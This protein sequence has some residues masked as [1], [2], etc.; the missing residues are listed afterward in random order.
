MRRTTSLPR[1]LPLCA[2]FAGFSFVGLR[3]FA[4]ATL[5]VA[6]VSALSP[7]SPASAQTARATMSTA[8]TGGAAGLTDLA[9]RYR[10][11]ENRL[12]SQGGLRAD[13]NAR[14]VGW[15]QTHLARNFVSIAMF[16]EY[17]RGL[18]G[19]PTRGVLR[20]WTQPVAISVSFGGSVPQAQRASDMNKIG[21][22]A[23]RLSQATGHPVGLT[24][25]NANV[26]VLV[27]SDAERK[28]LGPLLNRIAPDLGRSA[29]NA[30]ISAPPNILCMVVAQPH[31]DATRGYARAVVL[32][33]A[34]HPPRMRTSCIEEELAQAMG[35][36][37]DARNAR[38]SIFNDN[39][40]FGVLTNH[41]QALL[42]MLYDPR[43]KPGM[44]LAQVEPMLPELT[45]T[46]LRR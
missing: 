22:Y 33:R 24:R 6:A 18:S 8:A 37:N 29:R 30:L 32:I 14:G 16:S 38:P 44:N 36:P 20:R 41:D 43:L 13:R 12:V 42:R 9:L 7:I 21:S 2:R 11:L 40:E 15:D 27:V 46:A 17:G 19:S 5:A 39:E 1:P 34:E 45:R 28:G 31:R 4:A 23:R 10:A 35:L 3:K 25:G 26:H